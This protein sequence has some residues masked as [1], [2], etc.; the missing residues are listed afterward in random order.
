[1]NFEA[2]QILIDATL[3]MH[4]SGKSLMH[5]VLPA[6]SE[7]EQ[8]AHYPPDDAVSPVSGCRYFYHCHPPEE[9][10]EGE[11]GHFHLFL[12]LDLFAARD[13]LSGPSEDDEKRAE[14][15]HI[16]AL[17]FDIHGIPRQLFTT[18][19][20]VTDEYLMSA[21]AIRSALARF[22]LVGADGDPLVNQ[23]LTAFIK[24]AREPI[25]DLL[26]QRDAFLEGKDWPGEDRNIIITS[27]MMLDLQALIDHAL[28]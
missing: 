9:R 28:A 18:N 7:P 23:W 17:S 22:D 26:C 6:N 24:L 21:V 2:A 4:A 14:V 15:V 20:W 16:A 12:P 3:A 1:M 27:C 19:R 8:W 10:S 13:C 11:H 25:F 5:L